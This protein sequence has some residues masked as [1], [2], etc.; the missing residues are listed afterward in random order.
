M[1]IRA[2]Q[3]DFISGL[4]NIVNNEL[5]SI[6]GSFLSSSQQTTLFKK[7]LDVMKLNL[8]KTCTMDNV[9]QMQTTA[10]A[11]TTVFVD[12]FATSEFT[13]S[14]V[15]SFAISSISQFRSHVASR[16]VNLLDQLRRDYLSGERGLAPAGPYLGKSRLLYEYV[17]VTLGIRMHGSENYARFVNGLGVED[18]SIGENI[19]RIHEVSNQHMRLVVIIT[20]LQAIRDGKMQSIV[21]SLFA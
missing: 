21:V 1:D 8:E 19:S 3:H 7:L 18:V 13:D 10:A 15:A 20:R 2:L 17:R 16:A 5:I 12:F 9:D 6:F 11:T 14:S 4:E